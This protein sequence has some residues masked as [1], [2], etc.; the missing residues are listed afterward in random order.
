MRKFVASRH[1]PLRLL[2]AVLGVVSLGCA[3][4]K[5]AIEPQPGPM[6]FSSAAALIKGLEAAYHERQ[7]DK[8]QVLFTNPTLSAAATQPAYRFL[9]SDP[10]TGEDVSWG[11]AEEMRIQRRMFRPQ[12]LQPG[13]T[14]VPPEHWLQSVDITLTPTR[15]FVE[16]PDL[17]RSDSNPGGLD[18]GKWSA[19]EAIY[20]TYVFFQLAG[21][22]D[23]RV[24]GR[25]N[26]VVIEDKTKTN[27]DPGKWLIYRWEDLG[28]PTPKPAVTKPAV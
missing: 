18:P 26:F 5:V 17:Y 6:V 14:P 21:D 22:T 1:G 16:R 3:K 8:F 24:D 7:L 9:L 11:Y 15:E 23:Y 12:Y 25:A 4:R 13:E 27:G 20:T 28:G 2:L 10:P 19:T